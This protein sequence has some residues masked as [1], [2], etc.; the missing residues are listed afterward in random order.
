[1]NYQIKKIHT[2][3]LGGLLLALRMGTKDQD[4][5]IH[6]LA[7][8]S[9]SM[10]GERESILRHFLEKLCPLIESNDTVGLSR[11]GSEHQI[12]FT[13]TGSA[14][15][16]HLSRVTPSV[17]ADMSGTMLRLALRDLLTT[18]KSGTDIVVLS[19]TETEGFDKNLVKPM[20]RNGHRVFGVG[21]GVTVDTGEMLIKLS[22]ATGG[23]TT[24]VETKPSASDAAEALA[25]LTAKRPVSRH[26]GCLVATSVAL[27]VL[28]LV[29]TGTGIID[30]S[31]YLLEA[32]PD[33]WSRIE[34]FA[35]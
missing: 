33:F 35:E 5:S 34:R 11:F 25:R 12:I 28:V 15:R 8:C 14:A 29:L 4:R 9:L 10:I 26:L 32:W 16:M 2:Q 30:F 31:T 13:E 21:I 20:R 19:D 3:P 17:R 6:I 18:L 24:F 1:M 7:D 27:G 23:A 22:A